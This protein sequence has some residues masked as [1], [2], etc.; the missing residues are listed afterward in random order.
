MKIPG[1]F[2]VIEKNANLP[3][4]QDKEYVFASKLT[5]SSVYGQ[6]FNKKTFRK[7]PGE[8]GDDAVL[9]AFCKRQGLLLE[10]EVRDYIENELQGALLSYS[11]GP[12]LFHVP[13][14]PSGY[15]IVSHLLL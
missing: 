14:L 5:K 7:F 8:S 1:K 9:E 12:S 6:T 13:Q 11:E 4:L 15:K 3:N 10:E 2:I